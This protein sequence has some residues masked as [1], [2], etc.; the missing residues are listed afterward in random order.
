MPW[1]AL[2][3]SER[4]RKADLSK[5]YKVKGIP[6]LVLID[7]NGKTITLDGRSAVSSD[8]KGEEFPWIPKTVAELLE[9]N[10]RKPDGSIVPSSAIQG[11]NIALYFSAHW[12]PPCRGFTP[13]LAEVYK[14]MKASGK[15]D[16]EFVFI[17]SDRD[18]ASFNEY[19]GEQPWLAL[20]FDKRKEKEALSSL[21]DVQGIPSLVTLNA[22]GGVINKS[23]RGPASEDPTGASFPWKPKPMEDLTK[24]VESNGFD[25]NEK[26]AVLLLC[27]GASD[28]VKQQCSETLMTVATELSVGEDPDFIFFIAAQHAGPVP[29]VKKLIGFQEELISTPIIVILDIPDNGGFYTDTPSSISVESIKDTLNKY[30]TKALT[31]S[32]MSR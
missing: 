8:P 29:Q 4:E 11:K 16:F 10:L 2:P 21:F 14:A 9:G 1:L 7:E 17:S 27:D 25:V 23:A 15:D 3:F 32:Q 31:R 30:K 28:D 24:T 12:C 6:T 5:K 13:R 22:E 19:H 18:E 20:P 26:P